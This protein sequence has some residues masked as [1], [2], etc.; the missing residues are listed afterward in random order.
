MTHLLKD[1][2][3]GRECPIETPLL[4]EEMRDL[5]QLI[6]QQKNKLNE[7]ADQKNKETLETYDKYMKE[8]IC[9]S[10]ESAFIKGVRFASRFFME[11][12]NE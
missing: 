3:Y 4:T 5:E 7:N 1:I 2:W 8:L 11:A 6:R 9:L 10:E 12:I